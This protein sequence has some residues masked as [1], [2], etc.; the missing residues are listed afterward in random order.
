MVVR[1]FELRYP[2]DPMSTMSKSK[3]CYR[4]LAADD[5]PA[6]LKAYQAL[7]VRSQKSSP[8][9]QLLNKGEGKSEEDTSPCL[10]MTTVSQ[11]LDAVHEV[12]KSLEEKD[13]FSV[14]LMDVR[15]PPGI[16]GIEAAKR[17]QEIDRDLF[18]VI[19]TAYSDYSLEMAEGI[20]RGNFT[21]LRKPFESSELVELV[22][23]NVRTW[24]LNQRFSKKFMS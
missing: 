9:Q 11:G 6:I 15:M 1:F 16:D 22:H 10:Q 20:L 23:H 5:D 13:P 3:A 14:V 2:S 19:V 18:L 12:E 7:L 24:E 21:M 4:I 17:I 8:L